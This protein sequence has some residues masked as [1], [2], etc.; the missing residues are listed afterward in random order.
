MERKEMEAERGKEREREEGGEGGRDL[1]G[2][3]H[4][5]RKAIVFGVVPESY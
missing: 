5:Q 3:L 2:R 4:C 1:R